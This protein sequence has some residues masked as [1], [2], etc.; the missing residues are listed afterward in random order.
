MTKPTYEERKSERE[1]QN[2]LLR[3]Y[4]YHWKKFEDLTD[5]QR[6]AWFDT[7]WDPEW[8][9]ELPKWVLL[10]PLEMPV[11]DTTI[12]RWLGGRGTNSDDVLAFI[13]EHGFI[14]LGK[15]EK[16]IWRIQ[17]SDG[18]IVNLKQT[19]QAI[20]KIRV[21]KAN[22][23]A[24]AWKQKMDEEFEQSIKSLKEALDLHGNAANE[25]SAWGYSPFPLAKRLPD[26]KIEVTTYHMEGDWRTEIY[27]DER[28]VVYALYTGDG[29]MWNPGIW[30]NR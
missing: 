15:D 10:S 1:K 20:E 12:L 26:G 8:E 22:E 9:P 7:L 17:S 14:A 28:E 24:R 3:T 2:T 5:A 25:T 27:D 19:L 11:R 16:H 30:I 18:N 4:G 29:G 13:K 21:D 6:N 23:E